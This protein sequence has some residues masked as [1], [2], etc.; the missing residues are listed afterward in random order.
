MKQ[1][2]IPRVTATATALELIKALQNENGDVLF[3]HSGGCCDGS[4]PM[5]YPANEFIVGGQDVFL[6]SV[7]DAPVYMN[8]E[9]FKYWQYTQLIIDVAPGR[10]GMFSLENGTNKRF[11]ARSRLFSDEET[12]LLRPIQR[13]ARDE[14]DF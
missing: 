1:E 14:S 2:H 5:C 11:V 10:G 4:V 9:Q 12:T 3:H 7:G 6:G 8:P 13:R